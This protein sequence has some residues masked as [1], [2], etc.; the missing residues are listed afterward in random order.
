MLSSSWSGPALMKNW[1]AIHL[2]ACRNWK[3][4]LSRFGWRRRRKQDTIVRLRAMG[5]GGGKG[6]VASVPAVFLTGQWPVTECCVKLLSKK[7]KS[8]ERTTKE[9]K[10]V[11]KL[12]KFALWPHVFLPFVLPITTFSNRRNSFLTFPQRPNPFCEKALPWE[13]PKKWLLQQRW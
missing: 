7:K 2:R 8:K 11:K 1:V 5:A 12:L 10:T 3:W 9:D 4:S 6:G 13:T